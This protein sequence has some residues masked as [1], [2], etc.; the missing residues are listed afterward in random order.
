MPQPVKPVP[1]SKVINAMQAQRAINAGCE[2]FLCV[3]KRTPD[4]STQPIV[5][6]GSLATSTPGSVTATAQASAPAGAAQGDEGLVPQHIMDQIKL[7]YADVFQDLP[8]G[9]PPD[10]GVGHCIETDPNAPIPTLGK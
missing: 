6:L 4:E 8:P 2:V 5:S 3:V 1:R 10:R 9:L 7:E